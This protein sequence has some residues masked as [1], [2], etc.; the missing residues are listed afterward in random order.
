[1]ILDTTLGRAGTILVG[2]YAPDGRHLGHK[3]NGEVPDELGAMASQFAATIRM[4]SVTLAAS[5][6]HFTELPLVPYQGWI[7]SG[8]EM[9]AVVRQDHWSIL[10]TAESDLRPDPNAQEK[11]L[12]ELVKLPGVALA[13]YYTADGGEIAFKGTLGLGAEVRRLAS[14][15]VAATTAAW[16]GLAFA[17]SPLSAAS[18]LP[19]KVWIYTGGDWVIAVGPNCWLLAEA[20]ETDIPSLYRALAR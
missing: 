10:R 5:F 7:Y 6:S 19:T 13:V 8:G 20:G 17:F 3:A 2:E 16:R 11:G 18:W 9:T 14:S 12:E 1:M 15:L 4:Y